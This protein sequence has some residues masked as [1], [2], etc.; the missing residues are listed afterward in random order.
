M[1]DF[2]D[3]FPLHVAPPPKTIINIPSICPKATTKKTA[4][5]FKAPDRGGGSEAARP[6]AIMTATAN[7]V[8]TQP[9]HRSVDVGEYSRHAAS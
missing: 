2:V 5:T 6:I 7:G 9:V 4:P 3:Q 1:T 8:D